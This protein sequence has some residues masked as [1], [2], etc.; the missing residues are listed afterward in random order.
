VVA[1]TGHRVMLDLD[2][3][4]GIDETLIGASLRETTGTNGK[5]P[6]ILGRG[7]DDMV[8]GMGG[9]D[10]IDGGSGTDSLFG[11]AGFDTLE[12]QDGSRDRAVNCG[13][14]G[15]QAFRDKSDPANGCRKLKKSGR[16]RK[17]R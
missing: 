7:G 6:L 2:T 11:D 15:G 5:N 12:A 10:T 16:K 8:H 3:D 17:G 9:A 1:A 13:G 4:A 14:G